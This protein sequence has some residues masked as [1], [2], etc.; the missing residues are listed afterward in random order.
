VL[1]LSKTYIPHA[2]SFVNVKRN[3]RENRFLDRGKLQHYNT[4]K[5]GTTQQHFSLFGKEKCGQAVNNE[6][7]ENGDGTAGTKGA[8]SGCSPARGS[9]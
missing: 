6:L 5:F 3:N 8:V 7:D 9:A 1:N 4:V 2:V